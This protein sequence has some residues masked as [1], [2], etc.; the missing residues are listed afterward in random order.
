MPLSEGTSAGAMN[1]KLDSMSYRPGR[2]NV[3]QALRLAGSD[4]FSAGRPGASKYFVFGAGS[5]TGSQEELQSAA[6][7]LQYQGVSIMPVPIG[8]DASRSPLRSVASDPKRDFYVPATD[9]TQLETRLH[10]TATSS[11]IPGKAS[12]GH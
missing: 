11:I 5:E 1:R 10:T 9:V 2:S 6:K 12:D 3:P 8:G 7:Q 4:V